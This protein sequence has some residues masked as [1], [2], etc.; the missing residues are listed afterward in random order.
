MKY[1]IESSQKLSIVEAISSCL[2]GQPEGISI[3]YLFGSFITV[4]SFSDIDLGI[5]THKE[6]KRP[7]DFEIKLENELEKLTKYP[8]Y[9]RILNGA[10]L[11]FCHEVIRD[12]RVILD[13]EPSLRAD[14]EGKVLK[15]YFD[16][17]RFRRCY[18]AEVVNAPV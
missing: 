18:L 13:R 12:G 1:S 2:T 16:F 8:V 17:F 11:C 5:L 10:P 15:Q 9:V 3:A 6:L 14:F 7:L 4:K